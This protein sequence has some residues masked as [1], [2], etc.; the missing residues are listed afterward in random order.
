MKNILLTSIFTL[1]TINTH[2][3]FA[4]ANFPELKGNLIVNSNTKIEDLDVVFTVGC[5]GHKTGSLFGYD[6]G[7]KL[8]DCND[9]SVSEQLLVEANGDFTIPKIKEFSLEG[10]SFGCFIFI[11]DRETG[12]YVNSVYYKCNKPSEENIQKA[13]EVITDIEI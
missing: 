8:T 2:A 6:N 10:K 3:L 4:R 13:L 9:D 1:F 5:A 12:K 7:L 11:Q